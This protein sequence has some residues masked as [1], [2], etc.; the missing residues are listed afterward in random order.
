MSKPFYLSLNDKEMA[1]LDVA[2]YDEIA[3]YLI[4]KRL[5]DFKTGF[6]GKHPQSKTNCQKL[7][8]KLSRPSSQGKAG[9]TY[10][11]KDIS[12]LLDRM[13][14]KGLLIR[15]PYNEDNI[16]LELHLSPIN[17]AKKV[18]TDNTATDNDIQA[19]M[20]QPDL[21]RLAESPASVEQE[22]FKKLHS[23][24]NNTDSNINT[25]NT[26]NNW[27]N[28]FEIETD[29]S[30]LSLEKIKRLI[31]ARGTVLYANSATS[32]A[33]YKGWLK[34]GINEAQLI[35]AMNE[36]EDK[37]TM[38]QTPNDIDETLKEA[39]TSKNSNRGLVL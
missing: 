5:A 21:L 3:L 20:P 10:D 8:D 23:V 32:N 6:I 9:I 33:I 12:R 28:D 26:P 17:Y 35:K 38:T 25:I 15:E 31:N 14:L 24:M 11:R 13:Q 36:T 39:K 4:L 22:R 1:T 37:F 16:V 2:S 29:N 7:A 19:T 30:T 34:A 18:A 27:G